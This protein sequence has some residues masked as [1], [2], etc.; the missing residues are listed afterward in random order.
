MVGAT[1][2]DQFCSLFVKR[3]QRREKLPSLFV[4]VVLP[5]VGQAGP[6]RQLFL[7]VE[8]QPPGSFPAL[9]EQGEKSLKG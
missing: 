4:G 7:S 3:A 6:V 2:I 5:P 9:I 1:G 8:N